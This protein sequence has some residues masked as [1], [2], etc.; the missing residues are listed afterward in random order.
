MT[1]YNGKRR[2]LKH[3]GS[4]LRRIGLAH[5]SNGKV[6]LRVVETP[7]PGRRFT[8]TVRVRGCRVVSAP[9]QVLNRTSTCSWSERSSTL[10]SARRVR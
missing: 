6:T 5:L 7:R 3:R 1:V 8:L 4:R 10:A 9:A 2:L